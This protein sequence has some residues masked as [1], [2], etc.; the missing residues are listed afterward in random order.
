MKPILFIGLI[1]IALPCIL[2]NLNSVDFYQ[3]GHYKEIYNGGSPSTIVE[4][5][6]LINVKIRMN[7]WINETFNGTIISV[8]TIIMWA[9]TV[10][11]TSAPG[12]WIDRDIDGK[13][14]LTIYRIWYKGDTIYPDNPDAPTDSSSY[15]VINSAMGNK[16]ALTTIIVSLITSLFFY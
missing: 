5:E 11:G 2:A 3:S 9:K 6:P 7:K 1:A 12:V 16:I 8:D 10:W 13:T 14:M 4:A 15:V